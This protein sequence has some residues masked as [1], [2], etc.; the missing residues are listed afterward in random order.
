MSYSFKS[1]LKDLNRD[2]VASYGEFNVVNLLKGVILSDGVKLLLNY[3]AS[4]CLAEKGKTGRLLAVMLRISRSKRFSCF[5][6]EKAIID[7]GIRIPHPVGIII[8]TGVTIGEG[9][10]IYQNVTIGRKSAS[11]TN[12]PCIGRH[13][14]IYAGSVI[15]GAV[16]IG[17]H[18][19]VG[20]NSVVNKSVRQR[21]VVAGAPA[22]EIGSIS[23]P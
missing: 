7:G 21:V 1:L 19:V 11:D 5:I 14:E 9:S 4:R 13:V 17:D 2:I 3:R 22:R 8:G 23:A 6:S 12:Y 18:A 20:S 15:Q 16:E 10:S